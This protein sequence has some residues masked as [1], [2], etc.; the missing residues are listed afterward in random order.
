MHFDR[1]LFQNVVSAS[2]AHST[3]PRAPLFCSFSHLDISYDLL[4]NRH[5][6]TQN[7]YQME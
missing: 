5:T 6:A 1:F 4:L 7:L 2:M 3:A